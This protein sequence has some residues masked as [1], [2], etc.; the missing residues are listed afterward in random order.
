MVMNGYSW[1]T[2]TMIGFVTQGLVCTSYHSFLGRLGAQKCGKRSLSAAVLVGIIP[3]T[4]STGAVE[5]E[6]VGYISS[7][8]LINYDIPVHHTKLTGFI[9]ISY[10][11]Y[12]YISY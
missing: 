10:Y 2:G 12:I 11:I 1:L 9:G 6:S 7:Y 4:C 5:P 8:G 3:Q